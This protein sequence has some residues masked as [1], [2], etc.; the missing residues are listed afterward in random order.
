MCPFDEPCSKSGARCA[1]RRRVHL[2]NHTGHRLHWP[3]ASLG[4]LVRSSPRRPVADA[5]RRSCRHATSYSDGRADRSRYC[6]GFSPL[7]RPKSRRILRRTHYR[8]KPHRRHRKNS[9]AGRARPAPPGSDSGGL[10]CPGFARVCLVPQ[11][12]LQAG[13]ELRMAAAADD[14]AKNRPSASLPSWQLIYS[15]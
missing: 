3:T 12:S 6:R 1:S 8:V 10:T 9:C 11:L 13:S 5:A 2:R 4:K 7:P 15:D 14:A